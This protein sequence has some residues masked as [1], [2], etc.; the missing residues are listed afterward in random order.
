MP[1]GNLETIQPR[2]LTIL[3]AGQLLDEKNYQEAMTLLRRQR[4]D[5]NLCVDHNPQQFIKDAALFVEQVEPQWITLLITE[6]SK[7]DVT[8]GPYAAFYSQVNYLLLTLYTIL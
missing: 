8:K 7:G 3:S 5:L 6:L 2:A 4:I 1:R